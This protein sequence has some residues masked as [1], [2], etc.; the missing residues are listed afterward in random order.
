[1]SSKQ[2]ISDKFKCRVW[3]RI[4]AN[5][6]CGKCCCC[7]KTEVLRSSFHCGHIF[8]E[9][10]GGGLNILNTLPICKSCNQH[11]GQQ[12]M[13]DYV[14]KK[15]G[16]NLFGEMTPDMVMYQKKIKNVLDYEKKVGNPDETTPEAFL[17]P[18]EGVFEY[19]ITN[20][21]IQ[22]NK[23]A[24]ET[25]TADYETRRAD[26]ETRKPYYKDLIEQ[27][28]W[29]AARLGDEETKWLEWF[30]L[31]D[32]Y[33]EWHESITLHNITIDG[34]LWKT[35]YLHYSRNFAETKFKF[36]KASTEEFPEYQWDGWVYIGVKGRHLRKLKN[37]NLYIHRYMNGCWWCLY[38]QDIAMQ[39][40]RDWTSG[41]LNL[42]NL[43]LTKLPKLPV[44]LTELYCQGNHLTL[45][46]YPDTL[47]S[48]L[49]TLDCS[50]NQLFALPDL[51][52]GL[53]DLT[54]ENN[55]FPEREV[56]ESIQAYVARVNVGRC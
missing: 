13:P 43:G 17:Q 8:A 51:P 12:Y 39:R 37:Y 48:T 20:G 44:G 45:L 9:A 5:E 42:A 4:F 30:E 54:C 10:K 47:P 2:H 1:M 55:A 6:E 38:G 14:E 49:V 26:Y 41:P 46:Y 18:I 33:V 52:A 40:V 24:Y 31:H 56:N 32:R 53:E 27:A 35:L 15:F 21:Y 25:R 28:K 11:M 50:N 7:L 19:L 16:R 22:T 29:S 34:I 3:N 36:T 23:E